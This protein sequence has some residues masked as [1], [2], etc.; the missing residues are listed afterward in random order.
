MT[1]AA[2]ACAADWSTRFREYIHRRY[3]R[4]AQTQAAE[5]LGVS[6]SAVIYWVRGIPP[7]E[8]TRARIE[9]WSDGE[10]P[11]GRGR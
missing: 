11:A 2:A 9:T 4:F 7:R 8:T 10:V 5:S 1:T 6:N 3:P